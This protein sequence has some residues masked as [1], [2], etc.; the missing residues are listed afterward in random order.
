MTF[1]TDT[2]HEHWKATDLSDEFQSAMATSQ[3]DSKILQSCNSSVNEP[4]D[5]N[6]THKALRDAKDACRGHLLGFAWQAPEV[7]APA[8][9]KQYFLQKKWVF[10]SFLSQRFC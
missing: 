8:Q 2:T 4:L 3:Y 6:H 5:I 10:S 7:F 9:S 1:N